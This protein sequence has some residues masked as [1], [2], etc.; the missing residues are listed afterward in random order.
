[1]PLLKDLESQKKMKVY[2]TGK[3]LVEES[4]CVFIVFRSESNG[5]TVENRKKISSEVV[6]CSLAPPPCSLSSSFP[7]V[8]GSGS[9]YINSIFTRQSAR[10]N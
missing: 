5:G 8:S 7:S 1:M 9:I 6:Y 4:V 10:M 3:G 2:N